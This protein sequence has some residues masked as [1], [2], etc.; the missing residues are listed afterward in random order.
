MHLKT[1]AAPSE[2]KQRHTRC[3]TSLPQARAAQAP[4][5]AACTGSQRHDSQLQDLPCLP[6]IRPKLCLSAAGSRQRPLLVLQP[7]RGSPLP[8]P[9]PVPRASAPPGMGSPPRARAARRRR[10][11]RSRRPPARPGPAPR[12]PAPPGPPPP[13][14]RTW[15]QRGGAGAG[16]LRRPPPAAHRRPRGCHRATGRPALAARAARP[17]ARRGRRRGTPT[18][19][20]PCAARERGLSARRAPDRVLGRLPQ[21]LP[22]P[23][24]PDGA[25]P[26]R[27]KHTLEFEQ[28]LRPAPGSGQALAASGSPPQAPRAPLRP[29]GPLQPRRP[30]SAGVRGRQFRA[31]AGARP[32]GWP[33]RCRSGA[34][35]AAARAPPARAR[36]PAAPP[37]PPRSA[38]MRRPGAATCRRRAPVLKYWL[39]MGTTTPMATTTHIELSTARL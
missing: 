13:R 16:R 21:G 35:T 5:Q 9:R 12:P 8:I 1:C 33:G 20:A 37:G 24:R 36:A 39:G 2:R 6:A 27:G 3:R 18:G 11:R 30:G 31:R 17:P 25:R 29:A 26:K 19:R 14:P 4:C 10:R 28:R 38:G 15:P 22:G 34:S 7:K 32:A 23:R